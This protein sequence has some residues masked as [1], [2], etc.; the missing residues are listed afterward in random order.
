MSDVRMVQGSADGDTYQ[1]NLGD[2]ELVIN[3]V[4]N[5]PG[6]E[7][8]LRFGEGVSP[9]ELQLV[10]VGRDLHFAHFNGTD[11]VIVRNWFSSTTTSATF[12]SSSTLERVE[13]FEGGG[14]TQADIAERGIFSLGSDANDTLVGWSG[15]DLMQGGN[16][17]DVLDAGA[18]TNWMEGGDGGDW[19]RVSASATDN[20]FDG[21]G[22][23][24]I[25]QGSYNSD[26][27]IFGW[28]DGVDVINEL[29]SNS[30]AVDELQLSFSASDVELRKVGRNLEVVNHNGE[31]KVVVSNWFSSTTASASIST[32]S[33]LERIVFWGQGEPNVVEQPLLAEWGFASR[34]TEGVDSLVG[35]SGNDQMYGEG[36]NDVLDAG[37]GMNSLSGG[38]GNDLL[39][40]TSSAVDNRF[41]GGAGNDTLN[42][43]YNSDTY[44][45]GW[46]DGVDVINEL[47]S[48]SGSMDELQLSFSLGEVEWRKV[49]RNLEVVHHYGDEKLVVNNWFSSTTAS[50]SISTASALERIVF[51]GQ[52]E[53]N[54]VEQPLLAEWGFASRGTE[55]VDSLVGWSGNDQMYGEGGNDVLDAGAGMNSLSGGAGNDLL[56][57]TS[58]AVDNRFEGGAGNDT[59]NGSYNSDTYVFGWGDGVDVINELGSNS[60]SMDELQLSFSLGEVEWRK[61]GRNLEVVHHYGDEKLVVNNWFSS[62]TASASISTAS[63]LERIVFWGQG[64]SNVVEQP[65]LAEWGFASRGTE[66]V[67]SLVGWSGNDHMY[68]EGG[69]DVLDA[70]AGMNSLSGGAGNDL[71]KVTSSAVDNRFEGGAGNDTLNGSYN[72][73]TYFFG[74]GDGVDVI[75]ELRNNSGAVDV[76]E[77]NVDYAGLD[78]VKAGRNLEIVYRNGADKVVVSNFFS[79]T[80]SAATFSA[81][82][83]L[84][85]IAFHE[86]GER[87]V[88]DQR[89]F[90]AWAMNSH[91]TEGADSLVG[92]AGSEQM[93]GWGGDD[94]LDAGAGNWNHLVGGDGNDLLKVGSAALSNYLEGGA[95]NDTLQGSHNSDTYRFNL[96]DGLDL[97][98]ESGSIAGAVDRL[99][100]GDSIDADDLWLERSA[101]DLVIRSLDA[102]D[103]VRIADWYSR[104][105]AR[106]E[107]IQLAD[108]KQL[109]ESQVQSLVNAMA[110]FGVPPGGSVA[111]TTE[112]RQQLDVVLAASWQ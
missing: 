25:L 24:D 69:N 42:G 4:T 78:M 77:L 94:V 53:P 15:K 41:E 56:K 64:E 65:L 2:G 76:L 90:D 29:G 85:Q 96:G 19:L 61:V 109:V 86:S 7:D 82:S 55:G 66:G 105:S 44:V 100:I 93:Y 75:N 3:E 17:F 70:G 98:R 80:T 59:L 81:G 34:G 9:W 83:S 79:S 74:A 40:V 51:W 58:S 71:L 31:E 38:A 12:S 104:S 30:G 23:D 110:G 67:D 111:L 14:W 28:G 87:T 50:A 91:G 95:G 63:A 84:E 43:S 60:G 32:A 54:V 89:H 73:D 108:G 57:V 112:Q 11:R 101:N 45:F 13:F 62:T 36:G 102:Q 16:G 52:G 88:L 21:G 72:G 18:G 68:G 37:A 99:E 47:G 6:A 48:N 35:W 8:V 10:R 20:I 46:G 49:G 97:V 103:Q 107:V 33:A 5:N 27:Y 39:K 1:F 106:L 92:W 22:G 26:T